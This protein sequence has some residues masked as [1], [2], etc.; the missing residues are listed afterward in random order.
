MTRKKVCL[1]ATIP[2][3]LK[4]FMGPHVKRLSTIYDVTLMA[5]GKE[6]DLSEFLSEHVKF[7]CVPIE[8]HIS[9]SKD[10]KALVVLL[11]LFFKY[12]FT[13]VH[14]FTPKAGLL[15]MMAARLAFIPVRIHI[16]T[17][18][19]WATVQGRLRWILMLM[20]KITALN[21]TKVFSDSPSQSDFLIKSNIVKKEQISEFGDGS[22]A[23]VDTKRFCPNVEMREKIRSGLNISEETIL[24]LYI[25]RLHSEK[26][27][28]DLFKAFSM[29][30][31]KNE[32]MSL[33]IVGPSEGEFDFAFS[34]LEFSFPDRV[35]RVGYTTRPEDY[36]AAADV[37]CLPSYREGFGSVLIEAAA[38]Q[39][40][41]IASRI[42]GITDAVEDGK[43]G[44]LHE[45]RAIHEIVDAMI[46][47]ANDRELR[48]K[49][50]KSARER[51][52]AKF[53]EEIITN[54]CL[55][56]YKEKVS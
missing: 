9:I 16:F 47:L 36:I 31:F 18:Q 30:A 45:V 7:I 21:A 12:R 25:G 39:V 2:F 42:Y 53:S 52:I 50:G 56:F 24:F 3:A 14:S 23:G 33:L 49:M 1:I 38:A 5:N 13:S 55:K 40:P 19:V 41:S 43:T 22:F 54:E 8:R 17:G 44:I 46:L 27:L 35:H 28:I 48:L 26:G 34:C 37:F 29:A 51:A 15:A 11:R 4:V 32:K 6:E 20:D 10:L